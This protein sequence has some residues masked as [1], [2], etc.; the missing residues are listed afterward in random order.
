MSMLRRVHISNT[1]LS[2]LNNEFEVEPAYGENREEA[3]AKAGLIT[4]FI[5]RALKPF[6]PDVAKSVASLTD[7]ET[8]QGMG[9][10]QLENI[11]TREDSKDFRERLRKELDNRGLSLNCSFLCENQFFHLL[12]LPF[13]I[14]NSEKMVTL[15]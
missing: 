3:L 10:H 8:P 14:F 5:V 11:N 9:D 7:A 2:F 6:K 12:I 13:G 15:N 4:Y 1:T